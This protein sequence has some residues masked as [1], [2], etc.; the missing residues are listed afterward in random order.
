MKWRLALDMGTNSLG[1]VAFKLNQVEEIDGLLDCGVRIFPD[2]REP[3]GKGRVGDSLAVERRLARGARRNRDRRKKRKQQFIQKLADLGLMPQDKAARKALERLDPYG[4]RAAALDRPLTPHELGRALFHLSERR[5]Y[6]SN[7]MTDGDEEKT[8]TGPKISA[9]RAA[10]DDQTLGQFLHQRLLEGKA[11]RFRGEEGDY[12]A[13]R[14]MYENEFDAIRKAQQAHHSLTDGDWDTLRNGSKAEQFDGLFFQRPLK[15]VEKGRCEFFVDEYRAY[16]DLPISQEFRILQEVN[17]LTYVDEQGHNI[18]LT[19]DQRAQILTLLDQQKSVKFSALRKKLKLPPDALFNLEGDKRD[20]LK[21]NATS[22]DMRNIL[23]SDLWDH[24]PADRQN[25][26]VQELHDATD[27]DALIA[28]L[29]TDYQLT[30][31]E[32]DELSHHKTASGT[33]NVSRKFMERIN[34][35]MR[36]ERQDDGGFLKY[37]AAVREV[38][39]DNGEF[40]HHSQRSVGQLLDQLPYYGTVLKGSVI[41]GRPDLF[42]KGKVDEIEKHYGKINNPTVHV[43]LNQLRK[44]VNRLM[45][46]FGHPTNIHVEL[47]RELKKTAIARVEESK[48]QAA[49]EKANNARR[50]WFKQEFG[51]EATAL[52]LKKIRLWEELGTDMLDRQCPFSGTNISFTMLFNGEAEVE[53]I[54]PF[55]RTLDN[56]S[57]NLTITT[58]QANRLKGNQTPYEAFGNNHHADQGM[59]WEEIVER[60]KNLP[61]NKRWRF[62]PDAMDRFNEGDGFIARQLNDNAYI[63]RVTKRYLAHICPDNKIA[64]I[65]GGLT[66]IMRSKWHLNDLYGTSRHKERDDHRHHIVDAFTVGLTDR[67]ML[68]QVSNLTKRDINAYTH[69]HLPPLPNSLV[70]SFAERLQTVIVSYKPDHGLNGKMFKET[71]YGKI[72]PAQHDPDLKGYEYVTRKAL[73]SLKETELKAIRNKDL[74][75]QI[76]DWCHEAKANGVKLDKALSDFSKE[77]GVKR[78]R[79]LVSN[80]S[81]IEIPSAPYKSY[82]PDSFVFVD[83]WQLPKGKP[84]KWRKGEHDWKGAFWSYADIPAEDRQHNHQPDKWLGTID[85]EKIHPAAKYIMRLYKNDLVELDTTDGPTIMRVGGFSTTNNKIDLR[86]Q[87]AANSDQKYVSINTLQDK[88]FRK[89]LILPDG[90]KR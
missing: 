24:M 46:R 86:P 59:V 47:V 80:Q 64:T 13:D 45:A 88:N 42:D 35:I 22:I 8:K 16:K 53:H 7:R 10:M 31:D 3:A 79:L 55:S 4:L 56:S 38:Y 70:H 37:D 14:A 15:P 67:G 66:A 82:A 5:G 40:L 78:V 27:N 52:D 48:R 71:A 18:P 89:I 26:L 63:A 50:Q 9:L 28:T 6:K 90:Q 83:I 1:W 2:G 87:L 75:Q 65:P 25:D 32:A 73:I 20:A 61:R 19:E 68:Q 69:I 17:N 11:V 51:K 74:R 41:G 34:P 33:T 44:L 57:A 60:A 30:A 29:I 77:Y 12:Y 21:G 23:G 62:T 84:G 58:R 43:A 39:D 81:A 72:S 85:G 54:L 36:D 76:L 49:F